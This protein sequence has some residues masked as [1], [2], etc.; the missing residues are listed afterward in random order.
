[1]VLTS[2]CILSHWLSYLCHGLA[3][4]SILNIIICIRLNGLLIA[5]QIRHKISLEMRFGLTDL[6]PTFHWPALNF[7]W[8]LAD[9]VKNSRSVNQ[10]GKV[11][12]DGASPAAATGKKLQAGS[13]PRYYFK[14][15]H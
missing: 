7:G 2:N 5:D 11:L 8:T 13:V 1:M 14:I 15:N 4:I 3:Y 10:D 9:V 6:D 12:E